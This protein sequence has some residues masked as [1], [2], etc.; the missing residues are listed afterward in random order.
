MVEKTKKYYWI[1]LKTDFFDRDDIDFLMS[2]QNGSQ[3]IVLYLML[4]L[5]AAN[6]EGRLA[7]QMK[8]FLV[9]YD[10]HKI[11]RDTKYFD[12]DTVTIA[13]EL[14]K[15]LGLVIEDQDS[16]LNVS[17]FNDL[18]GSE[19]SEAL[20][21]RKYRAE[22]KAKLLEEKQKC[23]DTNGTMSHSKEGQYPIDETDNVPIE[24][25][26]MSQDKMGQCPTRDRDRDKSIEYRDIDKEIESS[27]NKTIGEKISTTTIDFTL[28][29]FQNKIFDCLNEHLDMKINV[30]DNKTLSS[31]NRLY[32]M[33]IEF[34]S[35]LSVILY[36]CFELRNRK[37][38]LTPL[39]I[40]NPDYFEYNL[41]QA[42]ALVSDLLTNNENGKEYK[43]WLEQENK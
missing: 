35:V 29:D 23:K 40:L 20:R 15:K 12:F 25:K 1:K 5:K 17:N 38:I 31:I 26:I 34:N 11:V 41:A 22:K 13:L 18:I 14:Y 8:E 36:K 6:T 24:S 16:V 4:C 27:S 2:Q 10:V 7:I 9:P 33:G 30:L 21:K 32:D 37:E 3:Y 43:K 42:E 19:T 39:N 28:M